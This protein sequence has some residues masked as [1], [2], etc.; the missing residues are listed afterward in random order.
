MNYRVP[1]ERIDR[2]NPPPAGTAR[3]FPPNRY[4]VREGDTRVPVAPIDQPPPTDVRQKPPNEVPSERSRVSSNQVLRSEMLRGFRYAHQ[5]ANSN[6]SELIQIAAVANATRE[7][8]EEQ[9]LLSASEVGRRMHDLRDKF[10]GEYA[11]R[12]MGVTIDRSQQDKYAIEGQVQIDCENRLHLCKASCCKLRF[13]LAPQDLEEGVVRWDT[14]NPYAIAQG[15]DGYC[16][17][18]DRQLLGCGIYGERPGAC[19]SYDCRKDTR[20]WIDFEK[21]IINPDIDKIG[22]PRLLQTPQGHEKDATTAPLDA[23]AAPLPSRFIQ[24]LASSP[25]L[26]RRRNWVLYSYGAFLS[27]GIALAAICWLILVTD[28]FRGRGPHPLFLPGLIAAAF[29]GSRLLFL[30]QRLLSRLLGHASTATSGHSFD[31]G[32]IGCVL[33]SVSVAANP[34][35]F[36]FYADCA[37]PAIALGYAITKLGCLAN[38]CCIGLPADFRYSVKYSSVRSKAVGFYRLRDVPL[39]PLQLCESAVA[40]LCF[41]VLCVLPRLWFGTGRV[42]GV[43]LILFSLGRTG[44]LQFRYRFPNERASTL[45]GGFVQLILAAV[46][47]LLAAGFWPSARPSLES[48]TGA[49]ST[50]LALSWSAVAA[51]TTLVLFGVRRDGT[52]KRGGYK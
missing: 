45:L 29:V 7:L 48:S 25:V 47:T 4:C 20:I 27:A 49:I 6:T 9:G 37:A 36:L 42:F 8:L 32:F 40:L 35:M 51:F 28:H 38:G 19:R 24:M 18:L 46:G 26:F 52:A 12:G 1:S 23:P 30:G 22:W 31:G 33:Y 10:A 16:V 50:A 2:K 5:R 13:S 44:A 43:L 11:D 21:G 39:F 14:G 41:S 34:A 15:R 17:H 3:E